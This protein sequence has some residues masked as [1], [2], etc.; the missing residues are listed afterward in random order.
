MSLE[1]PKTRDSVGLYESDRTS[2]AA[3]KDKTR[4]A[5]QK[6]L[7]K[8]QLDKAIREYQRLVED[9]PKD[10]RTLLKI[11][12]LQTRN[13]DHSKATETYGRVA[14]FYSE[15]G[16]FLKA[17]A[18]YKQ[19]L[20][21]DSGLV[22]V[23]LKLA[24]LYFQLGLVSDAANQ[25]R[26]VSQIFEQQGRVEESIGILKKMVE[27]DPE[28]VASRIKLAESFAKQGD[29]TEARNHFQSAAAYLKSHH[30][31]DDYVKVAERV[32]HF[33]PSD[34][35]T[36]RELAN[37]Y[38]QKNEPRRALAKLQ[39]CFKADPKDI[40]TLNLL[41][42]AFK[43]LGQNAK[44]L[45][46]YRELGRL[47]GD[48][49]DLDAQRSVMRKILAI[50]PN[51]AEAQSTLESNSDEA[52]LPEN[53]LGRIRPAQR[54]VR[55]TTDIKE[56]NRSE[57]DQR[58]QGT[59][60]APPPSSAEPPMPPG[61]PPPP[62]PPDVDDDEFEVEIED[63]PAPAAA[64]EEDERVDRILIEADV[65]IKY[66]L[67]TKALEHIRKIFDID[68]ARRDARTRYKDLLVDT[69]EL[70]AAVGEL[71]LLA[72]NARAA[73][74]NAA[75]MADLRELL[76]YDPSHDGARSVL[77]EL[78][79]DEPLPNDSEM[80]G[81][82]VPQA[83]VAN[84]EQPAL[85]YEP[86]AAA[87]SIDLDDDEEDEDG[88][89][90]DSLVADA[91]PPPPDDL[92]LDVPE[93]LDLDARGEMEAA[94]DEDLPVLDDDEYDHETLEDFDDE[95]FLE[96]DASRD[97][98]SAEDGL[99]LDD[100]PDLDADPGLEDLDGD[101]PHL[102]DVSE[103]EEFALEAA[104][105]AL[106]E[107]TTD[108]RSGE[109]EVHFGKTSANTSAA[110]IREKTESGETMINFAPAKPNAPTPTP[111]PNTTP[112]GLD[113]LDAL[114]ASAVPKKRGG[115][116]SKPETASEAKDATKVVGASSIADPEPISEPTSEPTSDRADPAEA[117]ESEPKSITEDLE[118]EDATDLTDEIEEIQFFLEQ[119]LEDEARE[120]LNALLAIYGERADLLELKAQ[121]DGV[122]SEPAPEPVA[123]AVASAS[124]E[125]DEI[126]S[127]D[128]TTDLAAGIDELA[129][130]DDFQ[131]AFQDVFDEFKRGVAEV[132]EEGDYQ[133]HYDLGIAYKEM[134]LF[135]DAI[136]EFEQATQSGEKAIGA[137]TMMGIC[138]LSMGDQAQAL[139]HFLRGLN[140]ESVTAD[141]ALA[142]RFEIGAAYEQMG[143]GR[144]AIKFFEK[145][146]S[147]DP[148]FRGVR[149]RL[150]IVRNGIADDQGADEIEGELDE[151]LV[152]TE[153]ERA[154]RDKGDKISYL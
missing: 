13:G 9:D 146:E 7:Q 59:V 5:A 12:D 26:Q 51:D 25:Y 71:M 127:V 100:A 119:S 10:V 31:I 86:S 52:A 101:E 58:A 33:D 141:E 78:N 40:E 41:A 49:G 118:D 129:E 102:D 116:D 32:I 47:H 114:L 152:E 120:Q 82:S 81:S 103:D 48:R 80:A 95:E 28:N 63:T 124:E 105:Q 44:T 68:P 145:V 135:A 15:Q 19:I 76:R 131:V 115:A 37:I 147:I 60:A 16:F 92:E 121:V 50:E 62:P 66:G 151:L 43:A 97:E 4:A 61:P 154:A 56:V 123:E 133:T 91:L 38:I 137:L 73:G 96:A 139:S 8:G 110:P 24:D 136:R 14:Q 89:E 138:A 67:K 107:E 140:S 150:T 36:T 29:A 70:D 1:G 27:L 128:L 126:E 46:V 35:D 77:Q 2:V 75:A 74:D 109:S 64:A 87:A 132:V 111:D 79:P 122:Q 113:D 99:R 18:V 88:A 53:A 22:E 93:T 134:G 85:S 45:S 108:V 6:Y 11:G 23:N 72:T 94:S 106:P 20:R 153:A 83:G 21:L 84:R 69:G 54:A 34:L 142:L 148:D 65:Y 143:R 57:E 90:E 117:L 55:R 39:V 98:G 3:N 104:T 42:T 112:A 17:V 149:E 144:E 130:G 125:E 30:R